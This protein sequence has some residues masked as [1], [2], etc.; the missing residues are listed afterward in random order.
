MPRAHTDVDPD[1]GLSTRQRRLRP[2]LAVNTGDGKGKTTAAMGTALRAWHQ[3]WSVGVFQ[4]IKS[5][6][7]HV[8]EQDALEALGRIHRETGVGGP[9]T[10]ETMGTGWSWTKAFD[11]EKDPAEA[12]REGWRHVRSLLAEQALD[13]YLLDEFSYP[14]DWG[15]I[16]VDEVVD[17]LTHRPGT[18]HVV[19][20]GRRAPDTLI[21]AADLVTGM[22]KIKHP[23]DAG[24]R[25]QAG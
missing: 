6:R 25:G 17:V 5:G 19:I 24:R 10:W 18:Q 23:F 4:F 9:V 20:T 14:L 3:G 8:G 21:E 7:W 11:A 22:T 2:V 12:A 13:F 15:W 1:D 16:D